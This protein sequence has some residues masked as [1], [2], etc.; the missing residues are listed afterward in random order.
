MY[1][2]FIILLFA[3]ISLKGIESDSSGNDTVDVQKLYN[4]RAWKNTYYKIKGDQFLFTTDFITGNVMIDNREYKNLRL[5]YDIYNDE[6]ISINDHGIMIQMNKE[7]IDRFSLNYN[8]RLYNFKR[9]D[10]D[11][12]GSMKGFVNILYEG[13]SA[14]YAKYMKEILLLAVENKYDLFNQVIRVFF[15]KEGSVYRISNK[16]EFMG[17]I[18]DHKAEVRQFMRS[19]KIRLSKKIP[20]SF[21]PVVEYYDKVRQ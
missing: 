16:R 15:E 10:S 20:E 21:K 5:K 11:T 7:M 19:N 3:S 8:G 9:I 14:L 18:K 4:G 6:L 13:K 2:S 1:I 12:T 17:L